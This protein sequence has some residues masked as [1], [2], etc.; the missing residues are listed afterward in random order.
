MR[1][2]FSISVIRGIGRLIALAAILVL[3]APLHAQDSAAND[4]AKRKVKTRVAAEYPALARQMGLSGKVKVEVTITAEG[5]VSNA[6]IVGGN[7]VL[8]TSAV[9][10]VKKWKFE[11]GPKDTTEIIEFEF[12]DPNG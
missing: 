2:A 8:V 10:A 1:C 4:N 7:P 12:K 6:K 9:D 11:P 5:K 3:A